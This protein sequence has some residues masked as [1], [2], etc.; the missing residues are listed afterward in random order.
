MAEYLIQSETLD[1]IVDAINAKTGGSSAMTPTQ[2]VTAIGSISGGGGIE[3]EYYEYTHAE[4]WSTAQLGGTASNFAQVYCNKGN[5]FYHCKVNNTMTGTG[6]IAVECSVLIGY[7]ESTSLFPGTPND[8]S[9]YIRQNNVSGPTVSG[10][11]FLI[12]AGSTIR[13]KFTPTSEL[14]GALCL[15]NS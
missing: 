9:R 14:K 10:V 8:P 2:M 13:V 15:D 1:D 3:S 4:D 11:A 5:G 12:G 7:S 6:A